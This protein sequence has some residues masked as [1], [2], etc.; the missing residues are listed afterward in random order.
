MDGLTVVA[1]APTCERKVTKKA[2]IK[3]IYL[4]KYSENVD[5]YPFLVSKR[6]LCLIHSPPFIVYADITK[7]QCISEAYAFYYSYVKDELTEIVDPLI[8]CNYVKGRWV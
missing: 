1:C 8:F 3:G 7:V 6:Y 4:I 5:Y 2:Q